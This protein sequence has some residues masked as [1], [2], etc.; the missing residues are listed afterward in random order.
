MTQLGTRL[1]LCTGTLLASACVAEDAEFFGL[2]RAD[3]PADTLV[4][5][6]ATEPEYLDPGLATGHPDGRIIAELFDGL[7][8][9]HP[10]TL[11]A[12]PAHAESWEVHPDGRGYT[13]TL[14][15]DALWTDGEPVVA[16][17]YA[18]SWE[19]N[20]NPVYL[21]RYAMQLYAVQHALRYNENRLVRLTEEVEGLAPGTLLELV[22]AEEKDEDGRSV[23]PLL[24]ERSLVAAAELRGPDGAVVARLEPGDT[25]IWTGEP[26]AGRTEVYHP[27]EE[28]WG[29]VPAEV[30]EDPDAAE[31]RFVAVVLDEPD[32]QADPAR[33]EPEVD[34]G[35]EAAEAP[36]NGDGDGDGDGDDLDEAEALEF[37]RTVRVTGAQVR[38]APDGLGVRAWDDG[39]LEVRMEGV[40]PYFLQQTSHTATKAVP[41]RAIQA[42]GSRW[43]RPE[44]IVSSGPFR[45]VEHVVRDRFVLERWPEHWDAG[46]VKLERIE[47]WSIDHVHTSTNL[48]RAGYTD[49]VVANDIPPEFLPVLRG[50]QDFTLSPA[51]SVYFYRINTDRPPL[52]DVRVRQALALAIDKRDVVSVAKGGELPASHIVPPGLPGYPEVEGLGFDPERARAL[53]AEAGFPGG[54]GF[55]R[56]RVLYNTQEKHKHIAAVI[57]AQWQEHLGI[58]IELENRE[59]KTYLKAVHSQ[60]YD[61]AR[62]GWIGDYLDANT[63]L[64]MW[65]TGGGNNET[66]WGQPEYDALI[67][68]AG[69]TADP[70]ERLA[71][72]AEAEAVLNEELPFIPLY[73]YV[74]QELRQPELRG[75]HPNL[76]DHHP[77]RHVWLDR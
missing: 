37:A 27:S 12:L 39:T 5:N 3:Q 53:L 15:R 16:G 47:A 57:Q 64:E 10:Q 2:S 19:R 59:W 11:E 62:G 25:V 42:H 14:R 58:E 36:A 48:Y 60:D 23:F 4:F 17:D 44:H 40:A 68:R 32:W 20:L 56:L 29:T 54:E 46:A 74:W 63:F 1:A 77:L 41:R 49:L 18:F 66:G 28:R 43:T 50:K 33:T 26:E 21:G 55:P 69:Q 13:F 8:E 73:W 70:A 51:L 45:L 35:E 75:H 38:P 24:S 7:T 31:Q 72:L 9:Y 61:I 71:V 52:D 65:L 34:S 67:A 6:N 76:L 22:E 30:L